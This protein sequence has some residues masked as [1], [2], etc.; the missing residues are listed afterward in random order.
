LQPEFAMSP[1]RNILVATDFT[2]ISD[3]ALDYAVDLAK[4]LGASVTLLHAYEIPVYGFPSGA[5]VVPP[6]FATRLMD[7]AQQ[8]LTA[9]VD[10]RADRGV[11]IEP[12]LQAGRAWEVINDVARERAC[13]LIVVG[14]H[15]RRGL[16]RALLGSI[17]ERVLRT[18]T[19]PVLAVHAETKPA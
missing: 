8:S 15:G 9:T 16:S 7:A 14:T 11:K 3:H 10:R 6:E 2:E 18:A 17:A 12:L 1:I 5:F 4:Q 19:L 13:D